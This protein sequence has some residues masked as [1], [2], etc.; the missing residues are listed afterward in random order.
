MKYQIHTHSSANGWHLVKE[1]HS[2]TE[3]DSHDK[4]AFDF[5]LSHNCEYVKMGDTMWT[6]G[7][8]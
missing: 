2:L 7:V 6:I 3:F 8:E 1:S 5:I 4:W